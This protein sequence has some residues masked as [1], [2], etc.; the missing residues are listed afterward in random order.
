MQ[1]TCATKAAEA[2]LPGCEPKIDFENGKVCCKVAG[3]QVLNAEITHDYD[4]FTWRTDDIRVAL[5]VDF[6]QEHIHQIMERLYNGCKAATEMRVFSH[7]SITSVNWNTCGSVDT[8]NA[9]LLERLSQV[10]SW[11]GI[12]PLLAERVP[13]L[14]PWR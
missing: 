13:G 6:S 5:G 4:K 12:A 1:C 8:E 2:L 14:R 7:L 11:S 10:W 9:M 3:K